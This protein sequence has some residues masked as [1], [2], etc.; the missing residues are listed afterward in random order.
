VGQDAVKFWSTFERGL[1]DYVLLDA[2]C[3]S[4]RH[5]LQQALRR[6]GSISASEWSAAKCKDIGALQAKVGRQGNGLP[7]A[8]ITT[9]RGVG[10]HV[11]QVS[12]HG[13]I[14]QH[15]QQLALPRLQLLCAGLRALKPGG[16]LVY[17]TCSLA[18]VEND[19][20]VRVALAK[21]ADCCVMAPALPTEDLALFGV[22]PTELGHIC[23]PDTAGWGP[24]YVA[25]IYKAM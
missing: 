21:H 7:A 18:D 23:L 2:P 8:R 11:V 10:E 17:S 24:I 6:N 15:C 13:A 5:V 20:V 4:D 16:R 1:Y 19:A 25:T 12:L 22:E 3:S 14:A 9:V